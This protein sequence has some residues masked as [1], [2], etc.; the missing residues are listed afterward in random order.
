[1]PVVGTTISIQWSADPGISVKSH[2]HPLPRTSEGGGIGPPVTPSEREARG[3][4]LRLA[5][6]ADT[7]FGVGMFW[8]GMLGVGAFWVGML[9]VGTSGGEALCGGTGGGG[10]GC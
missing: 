2:R 9:G 10:S 1:M 8:V 6:F 7:E 5:E 3:P 4:L